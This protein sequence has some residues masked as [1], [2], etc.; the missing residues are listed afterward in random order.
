MWRIRLT[1]GP[2]FRVNHV[3]NKTWAIPRFPYSGWGLKPDPADPGDPMT[4]KITRHFEDV[5]LCH[6]DL[7]YR[8]A[9]KLSGDPHE[10][11]DLVQET[12]LRAHRAFSK[13][14]L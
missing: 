13:F 1:F 10:A 14:E 6:L 2:L 12:F 5:V 3:W 11:E 8:M 9:V 4:T 7:V